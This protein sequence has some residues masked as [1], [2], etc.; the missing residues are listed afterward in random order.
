MTYVD[1]VQ[2]NCL[3]CH[4]S[5]KGTLKEHVPNCGKEGDIELKKIAASFEELI[6]NTAIDQVSSF[7]FLSWNIGR[8]VE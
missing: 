8:T 4:L 3:F 2:L 7:F 5:R 1:D 6:F